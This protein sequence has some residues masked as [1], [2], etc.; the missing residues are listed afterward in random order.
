MRLTTISLVTLLLLLG[1]GMLFQNGIF[2]S[3][4]I[5]TVHDAPIVDYLVKV[6]VVNNSGWGY[7]YV[8]ITLD[9]R[10]VGGDAVGSCVAI[11][12]SGILPYEKRYATAVCPEG[13]YVTFRRVRGH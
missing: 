11:L 5:S 9:E 3:S 1:I 6:P 10:N 2:V 8:S 7:D 13:D 12:G 4:R